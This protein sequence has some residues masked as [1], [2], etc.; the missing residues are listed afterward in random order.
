MAGLKHTGA[1]T[2]K[3]GLVVLREFDGL[4]GLADDAARIARVADVHMGWRD[5]DYICSAASLVSVVL[6]GHVVGILASDS[7]ELLAPI[8]RQEHLVNADEDIDHALL[9]IL[10]TEI[11]VILELFDEMVPAEFGDFGATMPIEDSE[12]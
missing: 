1:L 9:V 5:E 10:R 7:L 2:G 6:P 11:L 8:W 12:E 4:A 3:I